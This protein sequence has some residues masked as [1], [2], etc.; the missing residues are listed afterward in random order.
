MLNKPES[1]VSSFWEGYHADGS[2]AYK[3]MDAP[4]VKFLVRGEDEEWTED[5]EAVRRVVIA[6]L[7]PA[8]A[9]GCTVV[10][11]PSEDTPLSALALAELERVR[12]WK[13]SHAK[14]RPSGVTVDRVLEALR[15]LPGSRGTAR[16]FRRNGDKY[17]SQRPWDCPT[18]W[19][20]K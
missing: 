8:L 6:Q 4:V 14:R 13:G 19:F 7:G 2:F 20:Y 10:I 1:T 9:A 5:E 3:P 12:H 17:G 15:A 11:K 16:D 18:F